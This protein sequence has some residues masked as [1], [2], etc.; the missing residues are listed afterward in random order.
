MENN[1]TQ[2]NHTDK[3]RR[4]GIEGVSHIYLSDIQWTLMR[5][6]HSFYPSI[7]FSLHL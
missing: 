2:T 1:R 6:L 3:Q 7:N 4:K 5:Q